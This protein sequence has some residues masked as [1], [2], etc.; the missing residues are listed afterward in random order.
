MARLESHI[1]HNAVAE[2]I[3]KPLWSES[4]SARVEVRRLIAAIRGVVVVAA[5]GGEASGEAAKP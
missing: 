2:L 4:L 3:R 1:S 5:I